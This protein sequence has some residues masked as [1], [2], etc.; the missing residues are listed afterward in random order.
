MVASWRIEQTE[1]ND[2]GVPRFLHVWIKERRSEAAR[3]FDA[4]T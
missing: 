2:V 1:E 3:R 4:V